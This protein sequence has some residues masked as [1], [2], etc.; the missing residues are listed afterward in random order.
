MDYS[1]S[2][3][4][5]LNIA[6]VDP[7]VVLLSNILIPKHLPLHIRNPRRP[8]TLRP[9]L[10]LPTPE[11]LSLRLDPNQKPLQPRLQ[12]LNPLAP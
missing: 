10:R 7:K 1:S 6:K 12:I 11:P 2:R 8:N 9:D 5:E 4:P 3:F